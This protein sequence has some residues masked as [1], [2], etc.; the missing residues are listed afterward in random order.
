MNKK[1]ETI[2]NKVTKAV[3]KKLGPIMDHGVKFLHYTTV[4]WVVAMVIR[5][6]IMVVTMGSI[7]PALFLVLML[8]I[9]VGL[10]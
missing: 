4:V 9:L 10:V 2:K 6:F 7:V 1:L 5:L 8:S 3:S